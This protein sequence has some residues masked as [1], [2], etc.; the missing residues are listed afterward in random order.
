MTDQLNK[1]VVPVPETK[2][3]P[4]KE[5]KKDDLKK[6]CE[7]V[8]ACE[9]KD[10]KPKEEVKSPAPDKPEEKKSE[11]KKAPRKKK[12]AKKKEAPVLGEKRSTR[13]SS[14]IAQKDAAEPPAK[15]KE[16]EDAQPKPAPVVAQP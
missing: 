16:T 5:V 8:C 1:P 14:K 3:S 2:K 7:K 4:A 13:Q 12:E 6:S 10:E 15:K 9:K 11:K